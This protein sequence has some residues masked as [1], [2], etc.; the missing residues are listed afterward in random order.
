MQPNN[1][2]FDLSELLIHFFRD[3]DLESD[4]PTDIVEDFGENNLVLNDTGRWP[5]LFLLRCAVRSQRLWATW[6]VR[7]NLRGVFG[8]RPAVCF[9]EMP[10][11]AFLETSERREAWGQAMSGCAL[12]FPKSGVYALGARPVVYGLSDGAAWPP[13]GNL[14]SPRLM[15]EGALP[16]REQYRYVP[17]NPNEAI[18][19]LHE[20][21]WRWPYNGDL[22]AYEA[23]LR[24]VGHVPSAAEMPS[25][26]ISGVH[27][28]GVG[29]VVKSRNEGGKVAYDVLTLVD[30][31]VISPKHFQ[32]I[33]VRDDLPPAKDLYRPEQ[34][35][36]ALSLARLDISDF[37]KRNRRRAQA[38]SEDF[39]RRVTA[40]E[41]AAGRVEPGESG[42]CWL[43]FLNNTS[44]Y[45]RAL[46]DDGRIVVSDSGKY[47]A[48]LGEFNRARGR[49]Q[50][51][52]MARKVARLLKEQLEVDA[53]YYSV[54]QGDDPDQSASFYPDK[55]D[56]EVYFNLA[57]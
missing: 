9:S 43:W 27:A 18:D 13:R 6:A 26:D 30:R 33:I 29:I 54:S 2:R 47:L 16:L 19:W 38:D 8:P 3:V 56:D 41:D 48:H 40:V 21:E 24:N 10:L 49:L 57:E 32:Y 22:T 55:F 28:R 11:A 37:L 12:V 4:R 50:R 44:A 51:E 36:Q 5:A 46:L 35:A 17:Y 1:D 39:A 45:V 34:V 14:A 25:L 42:A 7:R 31:G 52:R 15:S 23:Q 20:R 53:C